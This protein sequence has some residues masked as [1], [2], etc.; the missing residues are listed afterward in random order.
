MKF[1]YHIAET[2]THRITSSTVIPTERVKPFPNSKYIKIKNNVELNFD[3]TQFYD[4]TK[5]KLDTSLFSEDSI[6]RINTNLFINAHTQYSPSDKI[7]GT[8]LCFYKFKWVI[9]IF[10]SS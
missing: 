5:L 6:N 9:L 10:I 4:N 1:E 3:V 2:P 7:Q 8:L